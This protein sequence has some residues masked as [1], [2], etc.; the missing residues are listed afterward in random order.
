MRNEMIRIGIIGTG[1]H[2]SRYANH[3]IQDFAGS[4]LL[5]SISRQ[6]QENAASQIKE[7]DVRFHSDWRELIQSSKVDAVIAATPPHLNPSIA[8]ECCKHNKPLLIEKPL[9]STAEAAAT[10]VSSMSRSGVPLTVGQTLRY[11]TIIQSLK[12]T[13]HHVGRLHTFTATHHLEPSTH[14]WLEIPAVAGGGV[15]LHT[16]V[17]VFDALRFITGKEIIKV[18][19]Y[20]DKIY[21]HQ[22][23]DLFT[24]QIE[25]ED[26]VIGTIAASKVSK[27]RSGRYEFLGSNGLLQADQILD[28][29]QIVT[30]TQ[31]TPIPHPP[32]TPAIPALLRDWAAFLHDK[33]TNPVSG[34][35]GLAAVR[36]CQA[37]QQSAQSDSWVSL[38]LP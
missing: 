4:L 24:A 22:L 11:N 36:I 27:S 13:L 30:D 23:E 9:A 19:A 29:I 35:E 6:S 5:T 2:G 26:G 3:I 1:K 18:R 37:C 28:S 12:D 32:L 20:A 17:H 25:M 10:M 7:W 14:P 33:T 16:A 21:N 31:V 38:S 34:S 8:A 15:I